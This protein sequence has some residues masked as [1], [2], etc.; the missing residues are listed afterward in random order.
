VSS[1]PG[2]TLKTPRDAEAVHRLEAERL[3][4]QHVERALDDIGRWLVHRNSRYLPA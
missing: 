3:E 1:D 4:D 2:L